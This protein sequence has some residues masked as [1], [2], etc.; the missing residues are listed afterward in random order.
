MSIILALIAAASTAAPTD[1]A[2][3]EPTCGSEKLYSVNP[4]TLEYLRRTDQSSAAKPTKPPSGYARIVAQYQTCSQTGFDRNYDAEKRDIIRRFFMHKEVNKVL[5]AKVAVRPLSVSGTVTLV[6][7]GRDSGKQGETWSTDIGN[8]LTIL[9]YFRLEPNTIMQLTASYDT[10]RTY[11]S[12][13]ASDT[14]DIINR[15]TKLITPATPLITASNKTRFNEASTFIDTTINGL[16][17][18]DIKENLRADTLMGDDDVVLAK[19]V[20]YATGAND[21]FQRRPSEYAHPVGM[22]II[23]VERFS[24]SLFTGTRSTTGTT[25]NDALDAPA[26]ASVLNFEVTEGKRIR[27]MLAGDTITTIARDAFEKAVAA[28]DTAKKAE[29][30]GVLCR[31]VASRA[32]AEGFSSD[33]VK[34]IVAAYVADMLPTAT[35]G[36][37]GCPFKAAVKSIVKNESQTEPAPKQGAR[38]KL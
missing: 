20:L 13:I 17:K 14:I 4:A 9:P 36:P 10:E 32:D 16:L 35:E 7:I 23:K 34:W 26:V 11:A 15:A 3:K 1:P 21:P 24:G 28:G 33:D 18:V 27:E 38:G 37:D 12:S 5:T 22:W 25:G 2:A 8:T 30:A 6:S 29:A 31:A 19:L